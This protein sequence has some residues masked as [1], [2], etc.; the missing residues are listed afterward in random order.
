[1]SWERARSNC[2]IGYA[3]GNLA[4]IP[5]QEV[6]DFLAKFVK[7][8]TAWIGLEGRGVYR[9]ELPFLKTD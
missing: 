4:V 2:R 7:T 8:T 9:G 3:S 5:S 1:M 6:N